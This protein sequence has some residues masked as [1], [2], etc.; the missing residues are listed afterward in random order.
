MCLFPN[1][2]ILP[3]P[4]RLSF[5]WS[6]DLPVSCTRSSTM[7]GA[8]NSQSS[9]ASWH[10]QCSDSGQTMFV[11]EIAFLRTLGG[12]RGGCGQKVGHRGVQLFVRTP[13]TRKNAIFCTPDRDPTSKAPSRY[14]SGPK[15]EGKFLRS[16][17]YFPAA[18]FV[19]ARRPNTNAVAK[20]MPA[21][22]TGYST[23]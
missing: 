15:R 17:V 18:A 9:A 22:V 23:A 14:G 7:P 10:R 11:Q 5:A 6:T 19:P 13:K 4:T 12:T 8:T 20:L 2:Y 16:R 3:T 1:S 21:S